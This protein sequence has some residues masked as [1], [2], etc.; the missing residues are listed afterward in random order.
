MEPAGIIILKGCNVI[1]IEFPRKN[2]NTHVTVVRVQDVAVLAKCKH[3]IVINVHRMH[4][5]N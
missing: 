5:R 4:K 1:I 3:D 2:Y